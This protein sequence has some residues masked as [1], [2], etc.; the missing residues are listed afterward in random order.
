MISLSE[1][2]YLAVQGVNNMPSEE[3]N[4]SLRLLSLI[5]LYQV[6]SET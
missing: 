4:T 6:P 2:S 5:A 3:P 1:F